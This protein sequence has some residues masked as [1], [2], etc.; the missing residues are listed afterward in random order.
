M[1]M[2]QIK[3]KVPRFREMENLF[4]Q[5]RMEVVVVVGNE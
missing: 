5:T 3:K 1:R 4:F 2:R